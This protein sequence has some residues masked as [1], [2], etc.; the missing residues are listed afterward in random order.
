MV[1]G[2]W[3]EAKGSYWWG[4]IQELD[5]NGS[6]TVLIRLPAHPPPAQ[7][8]LLLGELGHGHDAEADEDPEE[9]PST[10]PPTLHHTTLPLR[11]IF[12]TTIRL[13]VSLP[14]SLDLC[15]CVHIG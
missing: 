5:G 4:S 7:G 12:N 1:T 9:L 10:L 2:T 3:G 13:H 6:A 11:A 14:L 15:V 8:H